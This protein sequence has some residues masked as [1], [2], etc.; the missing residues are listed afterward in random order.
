LNPD[1]YNATTQKSESIKLLNF[2]PQVQL[3]DA[4]KNLLVTN[5]ESAIRAK[6]LVPDK[7]VKKKVTVKKQILKS[8]QQKPIADE[9][10][11]DNANLD[12]GFS[13]DSLEQEHEHAVE[14]PEGMDDGQILDSLRN[15]Q[16]ND[17]ELRREF[18][19]LETS[20]QNI[21][22]K[23]NQFSADNLRRS[24]GQTSLDISE[25]S[26]YG[27]E[28][29]HPDQAWIIDT[30]PNAIRQNP[31]LLN[32]LIGYEP[33]LKRLQG[34]DIKSW[35]D[36]ELVRS[37]RDLTHFLVE[38][39]R[40]EMQHQRIPP[41]RD[42]EMRLTGESR[43]RAP[44]ESNH[45]LATVSRPMP[46]DP[47]TEMTKTSPPAPVAPQPS[48]QAPQQVQPQVLQSRAQ[49]VETRPQ[50]TPQP[51]Q[52]VLQPQHR[53]PS[54]VDESLEN[55]SFS[56]DSSMDDSFRS[57]MYV[58]S[59][60]NQNVDDL[61]FINQKFPEATAEEIS[62]LHRNS[63]LVAK[64]YKDYTLFKMMK[65]DKIKNI[66]ELFSILERIYQLRN[67]E[68]DKT[69]LEMNNA[70]EMEKND[71]SANILGQ[72]GQT[73]STRPTYPEV[74]TYSNPN[75][76]NLQNLP[77]R[78]LNLNSVGLVPIPANTYPPNMPI[79]HPHLQ[80]HQNNGYPAIPEAYPPSG[81]QAQSPSSS[82]PFLDDAVPSQ[83]HGSQGY[84]GVPHSS[85]T[86]D[87][88]QPTNPSAASSGHTYNSPGQG[89]EHP[90]SVSFNPFL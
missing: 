49:Q 65:K 61:T 29:H 33:T 87:P 19:R 42:R 60:D 34:L 4:E 39:I 45:L 18:N 24:K 8:E 57:S 90:N 37:N 69:L 86:P 44:Q 40:V 66:P 27:V 72:Q 53:Q 70:E 5:M 77:L 58:P 59:V 83:P 28:N 47:L 26:G 55:M 76:S 62:V 25:L 3:T 48:K 82:N 41:S 14:S 63:R 68:I 64:R 17:S 85:H 36:S 1:D 22:Q 20:Q 75:S 80:L 7:P 43:L 11:R 74:F 9:S 78:T 13:L 54:G 32:D 35:L 10:S 2:V 81:W 15:A 30:F 21:N 12:E 73:A 56:R 23:V 38:M 50:I 71:P 51:T 31:D 79:S 89:T 46:S 52:R 67:D 6:A 84:S 16:N 88:P